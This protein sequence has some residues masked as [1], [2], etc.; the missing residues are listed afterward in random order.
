MKFFLLLNI[1][2]PTIVGILI[3]IGR[4]KFHAQLCFAGKK[5]KLLVF[6]FLQVEQISILS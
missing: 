6:N 3:F 2:M 1:K 5:F 4:E